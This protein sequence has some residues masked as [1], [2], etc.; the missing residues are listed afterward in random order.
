MG[1]YYGCVRSKKNFFNTKSA[2][3]VQA[4]TACKKRHHVLFDFTHESRWYFSEIEII[5]K[6]TARP[7]V[8]KIFVDANFACRIKG[9]SAGS[10]ICYLK[11]YSSKFTI[12]NLTWSA[13]SI[14]SKRRLSCSFPNTFIFQP[15][16]YPSLPRRHF[17]RVC[18]SITSQSIDVECCS[19]PLRQRSPNVLGG[20]P[21]TRSY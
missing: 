19:N 10:E 16:K 21:S 14:N 2:C 20:G 9:I 15:I 13:S 6:T 17:F 8:N 3:L 12:T 1:A 11:W 18:N 7:F 4:I 5:K